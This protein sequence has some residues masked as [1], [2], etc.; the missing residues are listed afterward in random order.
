MLK[1]CSVRGFTLIELLVVIAVI[2]ILASIIFPVFTKAK[3][4][5]RQTTCLAN[6]KQIGLAFS[7]YLEDYEDYY[8][9]CA[10]VDNY[11]MVPQTDPTYPGYV[12]ASSIGYQGQY[13]GHNITW[14]DE[15]FPYIKNIRIL[16]CPSSTL[17]AGTVYACLSGDRDGNASGSGYAYN[18]QLGG[19]TLPA[20]PV[21]NSCVIQN[22][23]ELVLVLDD[24]DA[25]VSMV[26][27]NAFVANGIPEDRYFGPHNI[28]LHPHNNGDNCLYAD[29]HAKWLNPNDPSL[30]SETQ[31]GAEMAAWDPYYPTKNPGLY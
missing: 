28:S 1:R 3:E 9:P 23:S 11:G 24:T 19:G 15:I 30:Y 2:A 5:A 25:D 22:P 7:M 31:D 29:N 6:L 12:F 10:Y 26:I 18:T 17:E 16:K 13:L 8:P 21:V 14:R 20:I 4:K 27:N